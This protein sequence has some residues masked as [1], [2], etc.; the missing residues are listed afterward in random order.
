MT[1]TCTNG[2]DYECVTHGLKAVADQASGKAISKRNRL[3]HRSEK[4]RRR[5]DFLAGIKAERMRLKPWCEVCGTEGWETRLDLHHIVKRSQGPR[6][7]G[8]EHGVDRPQNLSLLCRSCH[9]ITHNHPD[10]CRTDDIA[11][12]GKE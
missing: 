12:E 8:E 5:E 10:F 7:D 11:L 9:R 4:Q 3:R 6:Y 1:C 2:I